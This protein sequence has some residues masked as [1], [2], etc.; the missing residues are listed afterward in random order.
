MLA[1]YYGLGLFLDSYDS[2]FVDSTRVYIEGHSQSITPTEDAEVISFSDPLSGK[3]Y[4]A[5][6]KANSDRF[7]PAYHMVEQLRDMLLGDDPE[8]SSIEDLQEKYNYS[9]YQFIVDKLELLRAMNYAYD[10][11]E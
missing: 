6:R 9:D 1:A 8:F 7:Y 4:S 11:S 3:V 10:Y 2:S 5:T